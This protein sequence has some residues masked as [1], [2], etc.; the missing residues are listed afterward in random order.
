MLLDVFPGGRKII[1]KGRA[2]QHP[3]PGE[4]QFFWQNNSFFERPRAH[5]PPPPAVLMELKQFCLC[6][7]QFYMKFP[8]KSYLE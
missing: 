2:Q 5:L 4:K 1:Q 7:Q 3:F 6:S 8:K